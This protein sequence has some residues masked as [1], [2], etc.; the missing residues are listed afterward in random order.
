MK[1]PASPSASPPGPA[2]DD[3]AFAASLQALLREGENEL[4]FVTAARLTAARARA[5]EQAGKRPLRLPWL[6]ALPT[7]G[8]AALA[9]WM[10]LPGGFPHGSHRPAAGVPV[11]VLEQLGAD[12]TPVVD[13]ELDFAQWLEQQPSA[14]VGADRT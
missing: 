1:T 14:A 11:E 5:V 9:I 6:A 3:A 7:T 4:D 13:E 2:A 8:A 12:E 10:M